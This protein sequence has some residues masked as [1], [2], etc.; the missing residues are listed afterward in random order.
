MHC[1]STVRDWRLL[2]LSWNWMFFF[3]C[4]SCRCGNSTFHCESLNKQVLWYDRSSFVVFLYAD[5]AKLN[6]DMA[7]TFSLPNVTPGAT[8]MLAHGILHVRFYTFTQ[9][10]RLTLLVAKSYAAFIKPF[11][12]F[13]VYSNAMKFAGGQILWNASDNFASLSWCKTVCSG[14]RII[15]V[16]IFMFGTPFVSAEIK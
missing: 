10:L 6:F 7:L 16:S 3:C 2:A 12:N 4:A 11:C 8:A 15:W 9:T 13:S 5:S 14:G 1:S